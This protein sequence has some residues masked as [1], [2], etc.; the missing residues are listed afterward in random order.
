VTSSEG[1]AVPS[2]KEYPADGITVWWDSTRCR[3]FAECR[4]G[5]PAVFETGRK[6]WVRPDLGEPADIAE[7][8]R[9]CPTGALHYRLP[10][11][12]E[13]EPAVPTSVRRLSA[14]PVLLRGDLVIRTSG[15]PLRD[16]RA[17]L[18]GCGKTEN[19]PFC[20][21]ACGIDHPA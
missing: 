17:A 5:H 19:N 3:H 2:G 14:G 13:E 20:D 10:D 1:S 8:I 12:P 16:T 11:G 6:P 7:V 18:C 15:G 4:R 9:R 21:G